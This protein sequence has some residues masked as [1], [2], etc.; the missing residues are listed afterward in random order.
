[1]S[2]E[3][4]PN[5]PFSPPI[6]DLFANFGHNWNTLMPVLVVLFGIIFAT[7][8]IKKVMNR[9]RGEDD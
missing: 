6:G 9:L 2:S 1:M 7:F 8:V 3:N 4:M 5:I